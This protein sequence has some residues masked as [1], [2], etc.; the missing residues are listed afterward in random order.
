VH[1]FFTDWLRNKLRIC[2]LI[3]LIVIK[4]VDELFIGSSIF[5]LIHTTI[6]RVVLDLNQ[7]LLSKCVPI[8]YLQKIFLFLENILITGFYPRVVFF[9]VLSKVIN[10][11]NNKVTFN[12]VKAFMHQ[13]FLAFDLFKAKSD[14]LLAWCM[15]LDLLYREKIEFIFFHSR[16]TTGGLFLVG[17]CK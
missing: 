14:N 11:F 10:F 1:I 15:L 12:Q 7:G 3:G 2:H 13:L 17:L 8:Y 9:H 4:R 6:K 5:Y 16:R